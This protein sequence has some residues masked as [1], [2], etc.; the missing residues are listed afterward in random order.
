MY[1]VHKIFNLNANLG[2]SNID[3]LLHCMILHSVQD[4]DVQNVCSNKDHM[5]SVPITTNVMSSKPTQAR[6]T[7]Y[8]IM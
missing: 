6:C 4:V 5:Q 8:N 3:K 2:M 1:N 7:R